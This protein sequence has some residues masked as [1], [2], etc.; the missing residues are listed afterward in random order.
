MS[1]ASV[2]KRLLE[3]KYG[4][5]WN[6]PVKPPDV[7]DNIIAKQ[8]ALSSAKQATAQNQGIID[9]L[10]GHLPGEAPQGGYMG[11]QT[12]ASMAQEPQR[13]SAMAELLKRGYTEPQVRI[14]LATR[15]QQ[16]LSGSMKRNAGQNIG[17]TVG[18]ILGSAFGPAGAVAGAAV[19]GG[20][21]KI[22]QDKAD[23]YSD[24]TLGRTLKAGVEEAAYE[25]VGQLASMGMGALW[26]RYGPQATEK[27][28]AREGSTQYIDDMLQRYGSK[29]SASHLH[30]SEFL[31]TLETISRSGI[32]SKSV[33]RSF[34]KE[35]QIA[36]AKWAKDIFDN[37]TL[38]EA[39]QQAHALLSKP[40]RLG[41]GTGPKIADADSFKT[42]LWKRLS[43]GIKD[44]VIKMEGT[45]LA[46]KNIRISPM[47]GKGIT[48][49]TADEARKLGEQFGI[50]PV[51]ALLEEYQ[52][53]ASAGAKGADIGPIHL[54]TP[55]GSSVF[56]SGQIINKPYTAE[57]GK[58]MVDTEK[59]VKPY[60]RRIMAEHE[61]AGAI[62]IESGMMNR[63]QQLLDGPRWVDFEGLDVAQKHF[64]ET[65]RGYSGEIG[66]SKGKLKGLQ[67]AIRKSM[68]DPT[69]VEGLPE[70]LVSLWRQA[71]QAEKGI[72]D[73]FR[74]IYDTAFIERIRTNPENAV[75]ELIV[76]N[77]KE[78]AQMAKDVLTHHSGPVFGQ[79]GGTRDQL[80][81]LAWEKLRQAWGNSLVEGAINNTT[82][83]L[84]YKVLANRLAKYGD[85]VDV[86]LTASEKQDIKNVL[87]AG[88]KLVPS[89][90]AGFSLFVKG[91]Q[92]SAGGAA[93]YGATRGE[94]A[95]DYI[96]ALGNGALALSPRL[97]AKFLMRKEGRQLIKAAI[98]F[99]AG[100]KQ[101]GPVAARMVSLAV[102]MDKEDD[103]V[104][105]NVMR[106]AKRQEYRKQKEAQSKNYQENVSYGKYG[107]RG[108]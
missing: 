45:D 48:A 53:A 22:A 90:K 85:V 19:G 98:K 16:G 26:K 30:P 74:D 9:Q 80:G 79:V 55:D 17:G 70:N 27:I 6:E 11:I 87:A 102:K 101:L 104:I 44:R 35:N 96:M 58:G 106:E 63:F 10:K 82:G 47:G 36:L 46:A 91:A 59:Y 61:K 103:E 37:T 18:G 83:E 50:D 15:G 93:I 100:S 86:M 14:M 41:L 73:I 67:G 32:G 23:P 2:V 21:G 31:T 24:E 1:D 65:L 34:D 75:K 69:T 66:V 8:Q 40:T 77:G 72:D 49:N 71:S 4:T 52:K 107:G 64:G 38:T 97:M 94:D 33:W 95:G 78:Q 25:G 28:M 29:L 51:N 56:V 54:Q 99:P 39:G 7:F 20:M 108:L 13:R 57:I 12:M 60:I 92:I 84:N 76:P 3:Q 68:T 62:P 88:E 89:D 105:L 81:E 43:N 42:M 5:N